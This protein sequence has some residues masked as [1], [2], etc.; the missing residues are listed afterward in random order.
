MV[1]CCVR[2][3]NYLG[4]AAQEVLV[5]LADDEGLALAAL[6]HGCVLRSLRELLGFSR[7]RVAYARLACFGCTSDIRAPK[8][9]RRWVFAVVVHV[10]SV[11]PAYVAMCATEL[12]TRRFRA[13]F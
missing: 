2:C 9:A 7:P 12:A 11:E 6:A 13:G 4:L 3:V 1:A 10:G 8:T 5:L